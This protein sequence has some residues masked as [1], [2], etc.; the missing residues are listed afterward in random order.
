MPSLRAIFL[1]ANASKAGVDPL[2]DYLAFKLSEDAAHLKHR[3]GRAGD[4]SGLRPS[5]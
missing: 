1:D 3:L 4:N 2:A 5:L